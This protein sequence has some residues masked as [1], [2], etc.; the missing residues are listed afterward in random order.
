L[1]SDERFKH[2]DERENREK[3][4]GNTKDAVKQ[5]LSNPK[6]KILISLDY[7]CQR[8]K[9]SSGHLAGNYFATSSSTLKLRGSENHL[10]LVTPLPNMVESAE[11]SLA[12]T[13]VPH[14]SDRTEN[15]GWQ[16]PFL[17]NPSS[18]IHKPYEMQ[19]PSHYLPTKKNLCILIFCAPFLFPISHHLSTKS[20]SGASL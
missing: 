2:T 9:E 12:K 1:A 11:R 3:G 5:G 19:S 18:I 13:L 14:V 8:G 10:D 17:S 15:E 20:N 7:V 16:T 6:S 4:A